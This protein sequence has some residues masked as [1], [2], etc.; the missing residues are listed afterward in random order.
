MGDWLAS[1]H[2]FFMPLEP[3]GEGA[4]VVDWFRVAADRSY[5]DGAQNKHC[6]DGHAVAVFAHAKICRAIRSP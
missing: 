1:F 5:Y 6:Y 4:P 3:V 2:V